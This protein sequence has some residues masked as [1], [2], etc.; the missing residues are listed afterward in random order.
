MTVI[1]II[2]AGGFVAGYLVGR[3]HKCAVCAEMSK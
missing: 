2:T 1:I 3:A